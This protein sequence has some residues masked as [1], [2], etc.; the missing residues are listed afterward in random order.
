VKQLDQGGR[1]EE[2]IARMLAG[3]PVTKAV[4]ATAAEMIGEAK[5]IPEAP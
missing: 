5:R 1:R 3:W 4:R 2:N